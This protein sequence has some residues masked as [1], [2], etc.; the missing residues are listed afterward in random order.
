MAYTEAQKKATEKYKQAKY[1]RI[2]LDV[3]KEKFET[4]KAAAETAGESVN[5]YIKRAVDERM[6]RECPQWQEE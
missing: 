4:I 2:P 6:E 1:K 5:G 3:P